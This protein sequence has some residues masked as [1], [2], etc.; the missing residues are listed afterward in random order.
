MYICKLIM[1][2]IIIFLIIYL[3]NKFKLN[4]IKSDK[5]QDQTRENI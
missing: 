2:L 1:Y 5:L 3:Y 4:N